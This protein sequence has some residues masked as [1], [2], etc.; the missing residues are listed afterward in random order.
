MRY[1]Y[2]LMVITYSILGYAQ[3]GSDNLVRNPGFESG[4]R[5]PRDFWYSNK[6]FSGTNTSNGQQSGDKKFTEDI[7]DWE[8]I[9][10]FFGSRSPDWWDKD[11]TGTFSASQYSSQFTNHQVNCV[12]E[13][14]KRWVSIGGREAIGVK[15][16]STLVVGKQY[17][18]RAS[19]YS[20]GAAS[21][22][23]HLSDRMKW[24]VGPANS[25]SHAGLIVRENNPNIPCLEVFQTVLTITKSGLD[26]LILD[27][28]T[29][30]L[31]LDNIELFEHC[32]STLDEESKIYKYPGRLLEAEQIRAGILSAPQT[33]YNFPVVVL[34]E[35][36]LTRYKANQLIILKPGFVAKTGTHFRAYIAPCGSEC[37]T[38]R[39]DNTEEYVSVNKH[40]NYCNLTSS[41]PCKTFGGTTRQGMTYTWT[42]SDNAGMQYLSSSTSYP[43]QFCPAN[44]T[45]DGY[46]KY[47]VTATNACGE[48]ATD[49]Y[50]VYYGN[51]HGDA[52]AI[53]SIINSIPDLNMV[54]GSH[55]FDFNHSSNLYKVEWRAY[56][57]GD[58]NK[59]TKGQQTFYGYDDFTPLFSGYSAINVNSEN[60][61]G[62]SGIVSYCHEYKFYFTCTSQV[63]TRTLC[64]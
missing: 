12:S 39:V 61:A 13:F 45:G 23:I 7:D 15:L 19:I 64:N 28:E 9:D 52:P 60:L 46:F 57:N 11:H 25:Q 32:P 27:S 50:F 59:M 63:V 20:L 14:D 4:T 37:Q 16:E 51:N 38:P 2:S 36:G 21:A 58:P 53:G 33:S 47:T 49:D 44:L 3:S 5:S 18:L 26:H 40:L 30:F 42:C 35:A 22:N 48:T 17:I 43:I 6:T 54:P 31:H 29:G 55:F 1:I 34:P 41:T 10:V 8:A 24:F 56:E 62:L